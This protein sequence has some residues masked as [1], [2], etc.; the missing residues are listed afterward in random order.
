M[1]EGDCGSFF[2]GVI[3]NW[4]TILFKHKGPFGRW[5]FAFMISYMAIDSFVNII[6]FDK[7]DL[8]VHKTSWDGMRNKQE[9]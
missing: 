7:S 2:G 5:V 3:I 6:K 8:F 9:L 4:Q 1:K